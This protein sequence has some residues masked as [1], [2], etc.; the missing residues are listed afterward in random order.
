MEVIKGK[1]KLNSCLLLIT[2]EI[3][4]ATHVPNLKQILI[5]VS[6]VGL[7]EGTGSGAPIL[8]QRVQKRTG[9]G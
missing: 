9:F 1:T 3:T 2:F 4:G 8:N 5:I 6:L 7:V